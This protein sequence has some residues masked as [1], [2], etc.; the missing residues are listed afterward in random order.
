MYDSNVDSEDFNITLDGYSMIMEEVTPN[1]SFNRRETVRHFI[2]GGTQTVMRG[3]YLPRDYNFTTHLLIDP[4]HPDV[5]DNVIREWQSKPVEVICNQMGGKF[6]AEVI[7]KKSPS[8]SPNY[9]ALEIQV[10]EIPETKSLIPHEEV[11]I[12]SQPKTVKI[13]STKKKNTNLTLTTLQI[14]KRQTR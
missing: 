10:I 6:D 3:N 11:I 13:T 5:Y 7:I 14:L 4:Q 8:S 2:L 12:P 9:L 1:E